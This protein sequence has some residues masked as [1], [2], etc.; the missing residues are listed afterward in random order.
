MSLFC[1]FPL[2]LAEAHV[3]MKAELYLVMRINL[4]L[5]CVCA[6]CPCLCSNNLFKLLH[7][8]THPHHSHSP[9]SSS[10][11]LQ[12]AAAVAS[13]SRPNKYIFLLLMYLTH[14]SPSFF[15][16]SSSPLFGS[17]CAGRGCCFLSPSLSLLIPSID[18]PDSHQN[19]PQLP[20][21]TLMTKKEEITSGTGFVRDFFCL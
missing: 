10:F 5:C 19:P 3:G 18:L 1:W 8:R 6:A 16:A 11:S 12:M 15:L 9:S 17:F 7:P 21:W 4:L 20:A 2:V 14:C 13:S